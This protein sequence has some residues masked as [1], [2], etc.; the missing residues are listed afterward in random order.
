MAHMNA[1]R[2][3]ADFLHDAAYQHSALLFLSD[4]FSFD[5]SLSYQ[6]SDQQSSL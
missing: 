3:H 4:S 6:N 2:T 5:L 1:F